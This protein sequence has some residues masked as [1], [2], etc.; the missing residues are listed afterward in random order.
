MVLEKEV[1]AAAE[2]ATHGGNFEDER[3]EGE[4]SLDDVSSTEEERLNNYMGYP[5]FDTNRCYRCLS[6]KICLPW[7]MAQ[8]AKQHQKRIGKQ[9]FALFKV[10]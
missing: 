6:T 9:T 3:E 8:H 10:R 7:C 1:L 4:L 5:R 2:E